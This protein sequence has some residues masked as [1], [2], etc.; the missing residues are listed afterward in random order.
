MFCSSKNK[1]ELWPT[2]LEKAYAKKFGSYSIIEGGHTDRALDDLV[3]GI[4]ERINLDFPNLQE[5]WA[6][7]YNEHKVLESYLGASSNSHKDGD[8][9]SSGTGIV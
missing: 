8:K 6:R 7:I 2:L 1:D 3:A 5:L 4:P 9:A